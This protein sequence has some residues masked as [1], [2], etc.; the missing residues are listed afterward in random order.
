VGLLADIRLMTNAGTADVSDAEV[1]QA[2]ANNRIF[3]D[4]VRVEF[5]PYTNTGGTTTYVRGYVKP[6]GLF[7]PTITAGSTTAL[8]GGTV[9]NGT[10]GTNTG[11]WTLAQD[12]HIDFSTNQQGTVLYFSGYSYDKYAAAAQVLDDFAANKALHY[13]FKADDQSFNTNEQIKNL[14]EL[15]DHYRSRALPKAA[16]IHRV[17]QHGGVRRRPNRIRSSY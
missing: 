5:R 9:A 8:T 11:N 3:H 4:Q 10:G 2:L 14:R 15:A 1:N 7:D 12:G 13:S 6:W 16:K 17:D